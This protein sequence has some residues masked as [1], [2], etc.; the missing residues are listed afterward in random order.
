MTLGKGKLTAEQWAE[1][2]KRAILDVLADR[3]VAPWTEVE[4]RIAAG[5]KDF[6]LVQPLQLGGARREL[7]AKALV[8]EERTSHSHPVIT[9][10]LPDAPGSTRAVARLRGEKRKLYRAY[11]KWTG[12]PAA[13]GH[14]AEG[15]LL[16]SM[17]AA[18]GES[19]MSIPPQRT[20]HIPSVRNVEV[21]PG[22]LD[23]LAYIPDFPH[24]LTSVPLV[25]EVKNVHEWI[26]PR[27]RRLWELLT[28]AANLVLNGVEVFPVLACV[29][30]AWQTS[31]MAR[32]L[33]FLTCDMRVQV[34]SPD[35]TKIDPDQFATVREEFGLP[36]VQTDEPLSSVVEFMARVPRREVY[37]PEQ[38]QRLPWYQ[39]QTSRFA[40][41]A[42][43][44]VDFDSLAGDLPPDARTRT[45]IA[46]EKR[47]KSVARWPLVGGWAGARAT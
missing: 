33:G 6:R 29:R 7:V 22:P 5:W 44:V 45:L 15:V 43:S 12:D 23:A 27:D 10:R 24:A 25:V 2:G 11:L 8:V 16:D 42:A 26:Y 41:L 40:R 21:R 35:P 34:F 30:S 46:F 4:A 47:I 31:Q 17:R 32:D 37:D 9:L 18:S 19:G 28:K 14:H 20:G 39:L 1:E 36:I 38:G 3:V 13:C